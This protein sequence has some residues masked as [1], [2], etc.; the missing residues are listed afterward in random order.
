[1]KM[2]AVVDLREKSDEQLQN[3][4]NEISISFRR[5]LSKNSTA[6]ELNAKVSMGTNTMYLRKLKKEKARILTI[7]NERKIKRKNQKAS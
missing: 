3:R 7:L 2:K 6:R 4:L 1:M 5:T